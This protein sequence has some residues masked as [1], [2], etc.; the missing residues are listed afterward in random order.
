MK[1]LWTPWRLKY[2][3]G[4]KAKGCV[5][6]EKMAENRDKENYILY[7]SSRCCAMLNLYP[8]NNG[9]IMVVPY[10]HVPST[11]S[12]DE[13][14]LLDLM[15]VLN[16]GLAALRKAMNP[17]GFNI[18]INIGRAAGAGIEDHVHLHLVPRWEGDTN[19]MGILADTRV[20]P[21]LLDQTYEKLLPYFK[22]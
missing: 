3:L 9:H 13:E 10:R 19:F 22:E 4:P 8:Y 15:L 6:C 11:E 7:R 16:K 18:G 1:R 21:E 17:D 5:L 2:I 14:E 20:I 12:L